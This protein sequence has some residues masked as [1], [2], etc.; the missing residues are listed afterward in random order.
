MIKGG[1]IVVAEENGAKVALNSVKDLLPFA[2]FS[3]LF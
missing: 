2:I 1:D 3:T